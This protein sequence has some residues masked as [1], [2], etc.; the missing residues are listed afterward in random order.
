MELDF[1]LFISYT[2]IKTEFKGNITFF[3]EEGVGRI[4]RVIIPEKR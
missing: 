3:S 4:F 2:N 1:G